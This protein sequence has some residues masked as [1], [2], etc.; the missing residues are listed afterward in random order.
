M[1][2]LVNGRINH[3]ASQYFK[4]ACMAANPASLALAD[5]TGDINFGAGFGKGE[6]AWTEANLDFW[7]KEKVQKIR[8]HS[9]KVGKSYFAVNH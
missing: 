7:I 1:N 9:F 3:A 2:K 6:V 5:N 4:P 8:Q